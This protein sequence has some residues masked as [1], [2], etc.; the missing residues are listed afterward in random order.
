MLGGEGVAGSWKREGSMNG[1]VNALMRFQSS[2]AYEH[3]D[4][5]LSQKPNRF[6]KVLCRWAG[7]VRHIMDEWQGMH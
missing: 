5:G 3:E 6:M 2:G 7:A 4:I 1:T